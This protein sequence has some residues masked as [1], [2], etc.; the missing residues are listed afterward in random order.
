VGAT[1]REALRVHGAPDDLVQWIRHRTSRRTT[2]R[3]MSHPGVSLVLATGGAG[4]VKAAYRSGTPAIGVGSGNAPCY[5][6]ASADVRRAA[7]QI[8][9]SKSFDNGLIC[10]AEHNLVVDEVV[11]DAL[12]AELEAAGAAV[13]VPEEA[14]G[15]LAAVVDA[16]TNA[17]RPEAI[18]QSAQ[19]VADA[20]G[21]VRGHPIRVI[22]VPGTP[23][24]AGPMTGEKMTPI[25]SLFVVRGEAAGFALC[26]RIL[27]RQG[28]GHTAI[29]HT[30]DA[31]AARRFGVEMPACRVL[32]NSPGVHGASGL[33]S[34]LD[35]SFTIGCGTFGGNSTTDNVTYRHLLNIKRLAEY[36]EPDV[37]APSGAGVGAPEARA[38]AP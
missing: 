28:A 35:I 19:A 17:F 4:M 13:L 32:V 24:L 14:P 20:T 15:F 1:V 18:G 10:G 8:V 26:K 22:V 12:A 30:A 31:E 25:L 5:V 3:Y 9:A 7:R 23:D 29:I 33:T 38:A 37:A 2:T 6:T 21:I 34:G 16:R 27:E 36:V 11:R